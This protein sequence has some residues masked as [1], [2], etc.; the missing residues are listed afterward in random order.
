MGRWE[1]GRGRKGIGIKRKRWEVKKI[2]R[3]GKGRGK[4]EHWY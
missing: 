1:K 2:R 4:E 3:E